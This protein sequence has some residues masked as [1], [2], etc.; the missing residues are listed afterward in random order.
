MIDTTQAQPTHHRFQFSGHCDRASNQPNFESAHTNLGAVF[1]ELG[2]I[3]KAMNCY[4]KL[5]QIQSNPGNAHQRLGGL[6][7]VLGDI[8]KAVSSY[9]D[10][11][12]YE[13]ENLVYFYHLVDLKK[14]TLNL[15]LKNKIDRI[16]NDDNCTKNNR[17]YG[18]FLLSKYEQ[19][20]KN[21]KKEFDYLIKGHQYYFETEEKKHKRQ[22]EHWLNELPNV[23]ELFDFN[24]YKKNIKK[25][26][27][28]IKPIFIVGVPRCGSTLIEKIIASGIKYIPTGEETGIIS[29]FVKQK[30]IKKQSLEFEI[31]NFQI[32]LYEIYKQRRLITKESDF[33]FT[34]KTLDNF[35][36]IGLIKLIFP[37]AK[38][39]NCKRSAVS[40]IMSILKNNLPAIPWAH[41]LKH[42]L[43][44]L[45][46]ITKQPKILKE[47][48]LILFMKYNWKNWLRIQK[49]SQK[50]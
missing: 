10:A 44:T 48:F 27:H 47:F 31:E 19:K 26:N 13:P 7:V 41:N 9:Q 12:K 14:E 11:L 46:F 50:N 21:Y 30:L 24:K 36:F 22:V 4:K 34:D 37:Y 3:N 23:E 33:T 17:A 16:I 1:Q 49:M 38:V 45:I 6:Y 25:I 29:T 8:K 40:S 42:I 28:K 43:N 35:F 39:I 5:S 20:N 2:E 15:N 32:K 18:N